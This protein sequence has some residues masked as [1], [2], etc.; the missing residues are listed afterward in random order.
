MDSTGGTACHGVYV[1]APR[2]AYSHAEV[3]HI[4][5]LQGII[6]ARHATGRVVGGYMYVMGQCVTIKAV[7]DSHSLIYIYKNTR[8]Q[9][10]FKSHHNSS[11]KR[12]SDL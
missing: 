10:H 5:T 3:C 4:A 12:D 11:Q 7:Y 8:W 1:E 6:W 2:L 9:V